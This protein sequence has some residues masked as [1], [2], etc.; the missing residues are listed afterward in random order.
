MKTEN[1]KA[2]FFQKIPVIKPVCFLIA[3]SE[4]GFVKHFLSCF[5]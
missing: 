2:D 4:Y 1:C 5:A 3:I